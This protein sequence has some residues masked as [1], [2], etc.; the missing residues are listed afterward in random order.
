[1]S[2]SGSKYLNTTGNTTLGIGVCDRCNTKRPLH[3]LVSDSNAP[4]L[5]VCK[6]KAEG[7]C[8]VLDPYRLP[9]R[10]PDKTTLPFYRPDAPLEPT[11]PVDWLRDG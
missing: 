7:C 3:L 5:R 6:D 11:P 10:G 1:M 9:T 8:D 4:G 2:G